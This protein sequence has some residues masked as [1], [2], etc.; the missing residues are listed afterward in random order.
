MTSHSAPVSSPD[1]GQGRTNAANV[2]VLHVLTSLDERYGGP[3]RVVLDLS[4]PSESL[5]LNSEILG[6]GDS[7]IHDNPVHPSKI[8]SVPLGTI[9]RSYGYSPQLREWLR[10]HLRRFD[11][12]VIHGAW[13]YHGWAV[14]T[15]CRRT[16]TPYAY[17]P[18][19]MLEKWAL[20]GQGTLKSLK[21]RLYWQL[22][23]S[24]VC[25]GSVCTF[26]TTLREKALSPFAVNSSR[27]TSLLRPF[28][29]SRDLA[30]VRSPSNR[31]IRQPDGMNVA[32]FLGRLHPKKNLGM[33]IEAWHL[34]RMPDEW[35][36]V[37]A[38]VG[39][40]DYQ[41]GLRARV[42]TL[43]LTTQIQFTGFVHG[44][45]K[46]YLLQRAAWFLLPSSQENFGVAVLEAVQQ[47]CAVAISDGVYLSE[48]FRPDSAVLPV[49]TKAWTD[50]FATRMQDL[51]WRQTVRDS[52][53]D[54]LLNEFGMDQVV[55]SWAETLTRVFSTRT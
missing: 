17:F 54:H 18:H 5:G 46:S 35:R 23:E 4:A 45:D 27:Q 6:L 26:F 42:E 36:L 29:M 20:H 37:I 32:L 44:D 22:F 33:L 41:R 3:L 40:E 2:K 24:R 19:G 53:R 12:V 55:G 1:S 43:G 7:V 11:G 10:V 16:G 47:G 49:T 21:K 38:G 31:A 28:G 8:H 52:D 51:A 39:D 15:E 14:A 25:E 34:A 30:V 50:F 48:S 9:G 13:T